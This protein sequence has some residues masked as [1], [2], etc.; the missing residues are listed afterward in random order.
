MI[1]VKPIF[2]S[3]L[4]EN[5]K[6]AFNDNIRTMAMGFDAVLTVPGN[7]NGGDPLTANSPEKVREHVAMMLRALTGDAEAKAFFQD[8][9]HQIYCAELAFLSTTAGLLMPLN[10]K[11]VVPL[12]GQD[13]WDKFQAEV[14]KHN[15][16]EESAFVTMNANKRVA[17]VEATVAATDLM[18]APDYAP[19]A[20]RTEERQ[21][22]ALQPMTM[23]DI[24][25]EFLWINFWQAT[26]ADRPS[27]PSR[28]ST[29]KSWKQS[30]ANTTATTPSAKR[31][32]P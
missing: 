10:E 9:A 18:P 15:A 1:F 14:T 4:T 2:P 21:K 8:P 5:Q 19:E 27:R 32:R 12:V 17:M 22:L 28:P 25:E 6:H 24:V 20:I 16:G 31:C 30:L 29:T 11:N 7:Y 26:R 13:V 3:Y 23:A